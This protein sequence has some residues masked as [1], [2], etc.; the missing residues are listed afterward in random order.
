ML[1]QGQASDEVLKAVQALLE[2][3]SKEPLACIAIRGEHGMFNTLMERLASGRLELDKH[4]MRKPPIWSMAGLTWR[5]G[6]AAGAG[7]PD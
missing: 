4:S 2:Q 7:A 1:A 6:Q 3:E 5:Y